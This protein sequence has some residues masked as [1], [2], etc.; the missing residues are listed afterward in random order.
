MVVGGLIVT[1]C[2]LAWYRHSQP[3]PSATITESPGEARHDRG[4]HLATP[5]STTAS[6]AGEAATV[7]PGGV[8]VHGRVNDIGG[9]PIAGA[10]LVARALT[11]SPAG[12]ATAD[13][14]GRYQLQLEPGAYRLRASYPGYASAERK[15]RIAGSREENFRLDPSSRMEGRVVS[16]QTGKPVAGATVRIEHERVGGKGSGGWTA[17][18]AGRVN[19]DYTVADAHG[20]FVFDGLSF[21]RATTRSS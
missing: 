1:A 16:Q 17:F 5:A 7:D 20:R 10:L 15:L 19:G 2:V 11:G 21:R 6:S 12:M 18:V 8:P 13:E 4:N 9:G 3:A 14:N